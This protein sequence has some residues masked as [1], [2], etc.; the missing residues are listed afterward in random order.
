MVIMQ[1]PVFSCKNIKIH[2]RKQ[3]WTLTYV[4]DQR[5]LSSHVFT[6]V[7]IFKVFFCNLKYKQSFSSSLF[8]Y[9]MTHCPVVPVIKLLHLQVANTPTRFPTGTERR[10]NI[11]P[12]SALLYR[13]PR[14]DLLITNKAVHGLSIH[15]QLF[16]VVVVQILMSIALLSSPIIQRSNSGWAPE[17]HLPFISTQKPVFVNLPFID[18]L[19]YII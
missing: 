19:R 10:K 4:S 9:F 8:D 14:I 3:F 11:T 15:I 12:L 5:K 17:A 2:V 18:F 1:W 7:S 16:F 13:L 6:E